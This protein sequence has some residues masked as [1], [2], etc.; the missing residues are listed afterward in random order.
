MGDE[1]GLTCCD[2]D[3]EKCRRENRGVAREDFSRTTDQVDSQSAATGPWKIARRKVRPW[4][5]AMEGASSTRARRWR[6]VNV[7]AALT[8]TTFAVRREAG[9]F[10]QPRTSSRNL[11]T[12]LCIRIRTAR[13]RSETTT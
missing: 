12:I 10:D 8:L 13:A 3:A 7:L 1:H 9:K 2:V 5:F 4:K 11:R 6:L